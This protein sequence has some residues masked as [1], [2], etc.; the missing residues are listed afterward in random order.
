MAVLAHAVARSGPPGQPSC[1]PLLD[2]AGAAAVD[3]RAGGGAALVVEPPGPLLCAR[4]SPG[5][6]PRV[7]RGAPHR[8]AALALPGSS[9]GGHLDGC[10]HPV[11]L[12]SACLLYTSDAADEED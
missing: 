11:R 4:R 9:L 2:G 6:D 10:L 5:S 1:G 3:Y 8:H 12:A 7:G